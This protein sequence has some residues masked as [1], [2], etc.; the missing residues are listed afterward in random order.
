MSSGSRRRAHAKYATKQVAISVLRAGL[1]S[2]RFTFI[3]ICNE[4][5]D[6]TH[7]QADERTQLAIY[8]VIWNFSQRIARLSPVPAS[9]HGLEDG[10]DCGIVEHGQDGC[11]FDGG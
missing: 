5:M 2:D 8:E 10:A 9:I 11:R 7:K 1:A 3:K 6:V 4:R